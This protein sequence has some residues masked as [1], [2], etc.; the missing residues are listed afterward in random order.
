LAA[1]VF[2]LGKLLGPIE[3]RR[4]VRIDAVGAVLG[5]SAIALIS[6]GADA[7]NR[8]GALLA[9]PAAPFAPLGLSLAPVLIVIGIVLGQAFFAW[10]NRR[11]AAQQTSLLAL[12][13]IETPHQRSAVFSMFMIVLLG[14]A[15]GFLIPLY[16]E[17]VQGRSS[18][19]TALAIIPQLLSIFAAAILV[20]YLYDRL[21]LRRIA[22]F[23]FVL[24]AAGLILLAA[25]IRNEWHTLMVISALLV[26][27]FGQGALVTVLFNVLAAAAPV[28]LAGD[29]A[30]L[31]GAA[32]N[33]AGAVGTAAAGALLIAVLSANV[34][35]KLT[36]NLV[37]PIVLKTQVDLDNIKFVG[38]DRL[39]ELLQHTTATPAQAAEAVRINTVARLHALRISVLA[40]AGLALLAIFPAGGLPPRLGG[41]GRDRR[42]NHPASG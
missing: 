41:N 21:S 32:N 6:I 14:S 42:N 25:V 36:G 30:S 24:V 2:F 22:R 3:G 10:S 38:D 19:R 29:V 12:E 9:K 17:I 35:A 31:R 20:P 13:V 33:L 37:I 23:A 26:I 1:C 39:I 28:A 8:W 40:L 27:G 4:D 7:I 5:A 15:V 34:T 18:L 11:R 16:I